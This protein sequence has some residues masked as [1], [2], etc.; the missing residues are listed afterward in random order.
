MSLH[1][2]IP[3]MQYIMVLLSCTLLLC[4][5]MQAAISRRILSSLMSSTIII[6][7][8]IFGLSGLERLSSSIENKMITATGSNHESVDDKILSLGNDNNKIKDNKKLYEQFNYQEYDIMFYYHGDDGSTQELLI[9]K[10]NY[11]IVIDD[12]VEIP[13]IK[14]NSGIKIITMNSEH[15]NSIVERINYLMLKDVFV[16]VERHR[17]MSN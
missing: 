17:G 13:I 16:D 14:D 15:K 7:I 5:I 8:T 9:R 1:Q 12:N 3:F 2:F 11:K 6:L 4:G 10:G